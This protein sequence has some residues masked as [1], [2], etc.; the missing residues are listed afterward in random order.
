LS[1]V[2]THSL[3]WEK[4]KYNAKAHKQAPAMAT[5]SNSTRKG[6]MSNMAWVNSPIPNFSFDRVLSAT[7]VEID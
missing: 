5:V 1:C 6:N 4:L 7:M 3:T 2:V